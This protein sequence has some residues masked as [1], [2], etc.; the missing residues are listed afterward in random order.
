MGT[1]RVSSADNSDAANTMVDMVARN[2]Q[3]GASMAPAQ[4]I[5]VLW[6]DRAGSNCR[7]LGR[8]R[9]QSFA[10]IRCLCSPGFEWPQRIYH[11][12]DEYTRFMIS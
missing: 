9:Q 5:G 6:Y 1:T 4:P 2:S 11:Y 12:F 10:A 7:R 8:V 3:A